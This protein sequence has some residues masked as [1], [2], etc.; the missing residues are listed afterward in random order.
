MALEVSL[1]ALGLMILGMNRGPFE[2]GLYRFIM[3]GQWQRGMNLLALGKT[4]SMICGAM[5]GLTLIRLII[6][7]ACQSL[8]SKGET[9][10]RM[11]YNLLQY[12]AAFALLYDAFLNFGLETGGLIGA[13][14]A[15]TLAVSLGSRDAMSDIIAGMNIVLEGE[16]QVGD[17]VQIGD[18][19]GKVMDVGIRT[20]KLLCQG[21]NVRV[22]SNR[23][24]SSVT[25]LSRFNS[26]YAIQISVSAECDVAWLENLLQRELPA[27]GQRIRNILSGPIYKGVESIGPNSYTILLLAEC[28]EENLN[29]VHRSLNREIRM[30]LEREK[31]PLK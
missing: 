25:N 22:I 5:M 1:L 2:S 17:I 7:A 12:V 14:G 10:L 31:I 24:I 23:N 6:T 28:R 9:V 15:V 21:E 4:V 8:G 30:M 13:I 19:K 27:I 16:F 20:T 29:N 11:L 18:A 3:A 26:W